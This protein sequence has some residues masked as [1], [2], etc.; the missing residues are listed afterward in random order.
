M[1]GA[2]AQGGTLF[3]GTEASAWRMGTSGA[4]TLTR[5]DRQR[6]E[7]SLRLAWDGPGA[8]HFD[9][10]A[11]EDFSRETNADMMLVLTARVDAPPA[12]E[13]LLDVACG[14]GCAG[15]VRIEA[16]LR[17]LQAGQWLRLGVPLKCFARAG[18]DM[19]QKLTRI[20]LRATGRL[21]LTLNRLALGT[22]VDARSACPA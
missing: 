13:A 20:S 15:S 10:G 4:L 21:G 3:G 8:L 1:I 18:A 19:N 5:V 22:D 17:A 11:G 7:D 14:A 12:G 9:S 6:Q 16:D 2:D